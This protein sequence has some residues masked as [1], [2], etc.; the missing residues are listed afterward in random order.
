MNGEGDKSHQTVSTNHSLFGVSVESR[1]DEPVD[2]DDRDLELLM[3][4]WPWGCN[5]SNH[6]SQRSPHQLYTS[7][8]THPPFVEVT[9][10]VVY[11]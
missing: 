5:L 3:V 2:E 4:S 8:V 7:D 9:A 11:L 6:L 1:R 10:S